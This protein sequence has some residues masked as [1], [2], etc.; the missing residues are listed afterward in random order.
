MTGFVLGLGV[1]L[2]ELLLENS[3]RANA[4]PTPARSIAGRRLFDFAAL[5]RRAFFGA[6]AFLRLG[7]T[8]FVCALDFAVALGVLVVARRAAGFLAGM[9]FS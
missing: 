9:G 1:T 4:T 6:A 5:P 8:R 2:P 7:V 3:A